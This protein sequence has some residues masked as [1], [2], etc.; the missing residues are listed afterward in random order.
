MSSSTDIDTL[1]ALY[2]FQTVPRPSLQALLQVANPLEKLRELF[3]QRDPLYR[4][5][6]HYII[7]TGRPSVA[8]MV[9]MV[10]MQLELAGIVPPAPPRQPVG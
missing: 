4:E 3:Q 1:A 8:T 5:T 9:N 6:A 10:L 2:L 7:E